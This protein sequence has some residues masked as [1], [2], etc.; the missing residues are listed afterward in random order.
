MKKYFCFLEYFATGGGMTY[1]I[2]AV[3]A[4]NEE[5]A[6]KAFCIKHM[7]NNDATNMLCI[8]HFSRGVVVYDISD[9]TQHAKVK[10]VM[11]YFFTEKNIERMFAANKA[12]A[13]IDFYYKSY[14]NYS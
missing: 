9:E 2:A 3:Y 1:C 7:C 14:V 11:N 10:S 4:E 8:S 6:K 13:L 12:G 5:D